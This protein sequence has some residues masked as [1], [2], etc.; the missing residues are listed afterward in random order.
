MGDLD[1]IIDRLDYLEWLGVDGIWLSPITASSN[2]DWG[3]DVD[4]YCAVHPDFGTMS[5]FELLVAEA[6]RRRY[7]RPIGSRSKPHQ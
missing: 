6:S 4:D 3:Y 7:S 2:A 1:G 5:T